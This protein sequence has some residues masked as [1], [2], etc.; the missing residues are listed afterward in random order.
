MGAAPSTSSLILLTGHRR[1][2]LEAT[3]KDRC[4]WI[5]ER[6]VLQEALQ[7]H[8]VL[9]T[10]VDCKLRSYI[11][12]KPRGHPAPE[13]LLPMLACELFW[14]RV[15][16]RHPKSCQII[17]GGLARVSERS[18]LSSIIWGHLARLHNMI[19]SSV[20]YTGHLFMLA[21]M[22]PYNP[23]QQAYLYMITSA[24]THVCVTVYKRSQT[25]SY[26]TF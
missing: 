1:L 11:Y 23:S 22:L 5:S 20:T 3:F 4:A 12:L 25:F 10:N 24:H 16:P 21:N 13:N 18:C 7:R 9:R 14:I 19:H 8:V 17:D 2:I 15:A 26:I 6:R